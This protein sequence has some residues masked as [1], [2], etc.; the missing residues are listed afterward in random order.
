MW[1][2]LAAWELVQLQMKCQDSAYRYNFFAS[3][4]D[5]SKWYLYTLSW[6]FISSC[7]TVHNSPDYKFAEA[8]VLDKVDRRVKELKL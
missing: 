8:I 4:V 6:H 5:A 7:V 3:T 2:E 1:C